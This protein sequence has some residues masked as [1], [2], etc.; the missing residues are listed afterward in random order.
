MVLSWL[1]SKGLHVHQISEHL[2]DVVDKEDLIDDEADLL[3][4]VCINSTICD[5]WMETLYNDK[6][7]QLERGRV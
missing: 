6:M 1:Y 7:S 4:T 5:G 3:M 2:C